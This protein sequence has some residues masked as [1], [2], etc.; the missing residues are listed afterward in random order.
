MPNPSIKDE[1]L[2]QELRKQGDSKEKG[3]RICPRTQKEG[4]TAWHFRLFPV[5]QGQADYEAP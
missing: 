3:A 5:D 4:Q 2:Y 1:T